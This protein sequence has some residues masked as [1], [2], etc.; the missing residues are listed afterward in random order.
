LMTCDICIFLF[1]YV[2]EKD[3]YFQVMF[4]AFFRHL[5][6][7]L[8]Q[9]LECVGVNP[10]VVERRRHTFL[11]R[12][13]A[14]DVH[15][16]Q[17]GYDTTCFHFGSQSEGTTTPGLQSDTDQ[18]YT[19]NNVNIMYSWAD[20]QQGKLNLLMVREEDTPPQH[21]LLQLIRSDIPQPVT[22]TD[23]PDFVTDSQGRIFYSNMAVVRVSVEVHGDR[24]MRHGPS[25]SGSED[26]DQVSAFHCTTFPPEIISWFTKMQHGYWPSQETLQAAQ[27][28]G[29]FLV[30]VGYPGSVNQEIE[31][32][33]TPNLIE[34]LLMFSLNMV[35]IKCLVVLKMLKKQEFVKYIHCETCKFTTFHCKTALFFTLNRTPP[36]IWTKRKLVE[37][38]VRCLQTILQFLN[39]GQCP[40]FIVEGIDLFDGKLCRE[41]QLGLARA[42]R[43]MIQDDMH[44]LFQLQ[45]DDLG[46]RVMAVLHDVRSY[47]GDDV[48]AGICGRLAKDMFEQYLLHVRKVCYRL[49]NHAEADVSTRLNNKI[50]LLEDL[51]VNARTIQYDKNYIKFFVKCLMSVKASVTSSSCIETGQPLP[52]DIWQL[53]GESLSTDVASSKL[54]LASMHYCR[55]ELRRAASVLNEVEFD[56]NDSVQPVC[57]CGRKPSR[58]ILSKAFCEYTIHNDSHE[59]LTKKLAFCVKFLREEKFCAPQFLWCEMYRAYGNDVDHRTSNQRQWMNSAVVDARPFLLYLQYLTYR[60]LGARHRQLEAFHRLEDIVTSDKFNQLYH[61]ETALNLFGHCCE[62]EGDV[63]RALDVYNRSLL[64]RTR[65]NAANWHDHRLNEMLYNSYLRTVNETENTEV[66]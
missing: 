1:L 3:L 21:Y 20:W 27:R 35:P 18:L 52:Q 60:G 51:A 49:F 16:H 43:G 56:L 15:E 37:C 50:T 39:Q 36:T 10:W 22:H 8:Y 26:W 47:P 34:R 30:P 59:Q 38:I 46:Q 14:W 61:R 28:C 44:V 7:V 4:P 55:G 17:E 54:K 40:H 53:Y 24:H 66:S 45:S 9:V 63:M 2:N 32:R 41:C 62:L 12:E 65:N 33:F 23:D 42:I 48:N 25:N 29:C 57:W 5:S 6:L 13:A 31:W 19:S 64:T 11:H 58:D